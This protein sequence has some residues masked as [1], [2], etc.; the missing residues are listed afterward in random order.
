MT[1]FSLEDIDAHIANLRAQLLFLNKGL[2]ATDHNA[3]DWLATDLISLRNKSGRLQDDMKRF[4]DQLQ[5]EGLGAKKAKISNKRLS[6]EGEG[7]DAKKAKPSKRLSIEGAKPSTPTKRPANSAI[8]PPVDQSP[9]PR[10]NPTLPDPAYVVERVDVTQEVNRRLQESRLRRLMETPSTAQKRKR[11]ALEE[12][13]SG[14][15]VDGDGRNY[16]GSEYDGT[17]TKRLKC[18][19][20]FEQVGKRKEDGV[21]RGGEK[22]EGRAKFKRRRV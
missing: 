1:S 11:D 20:A 14:S 15:T 3:P 10:A 5:S 9:T 8:S 22:V 13:R 17:P 21:E 2:D 19:G 6:I 16:S 18:S 7:L 12:P 4:R